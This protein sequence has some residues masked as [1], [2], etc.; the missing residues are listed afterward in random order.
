[1]TLISSW[2]QYFFQGRI[3]FPD[4]NWIVNLGHQNR[5]KP[6]LL[7]IFARLFFKTRL[8]AKQS[9]PFPLF[10]VL[11]PLTIWL[12]AFDVS[13]LTI[14]WWTYFLANFGALNSLSWKAEFVKWCFLRNALLDFSKSARNCTHDTFSSIKND[15]FFRVLDCG[16]FYLSFYAKIASAKALLKF[17]KLFLQAEWRDFSQFF[18]QCFLLNWQIIS[19]MHT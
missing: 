2:F 4:G 13:S 11:L 17:G 1:M 14:E 5:L 3:C 19:A 12:R 9:S 10:T 6:F 18:C 8:L 7:T 16:I 15:G